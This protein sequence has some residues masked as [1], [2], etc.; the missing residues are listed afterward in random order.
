MLLLFV[1][2][3]IIAI[4]IIYVAF[5]KELRLRKAKEIFLSMF[6]ISLLA[7]IIDIVYNGLINR[8]LP[9]ISCIS[10]T[11]FA[12]IYSIF[13]YFLMLKR[14]RNSVIQ[15]NIFIPSF[16]MVVLIALLF[17][18]FLPF[19]TSIENAR[20]IR[21]HFLRFLIYFMFGYSTAAY[22]LLLRIVRKRGDIFFRAYRPK[23]SKEK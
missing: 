10:F 17:S 12:V 11:I 4:V 8:R 16:P 19:L 9:T 13:D 15:N 23:S 2:M 14:L 6:F 21:S 3:E 5:R 1:L 7:I 20:I 22:L 18:I